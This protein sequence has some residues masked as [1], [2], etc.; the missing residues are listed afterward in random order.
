MKPDLLVAI[1]SLIV[2]TVTS[3]F[4]GYI[5]FLTLRFAARPRLRIKLLPEL[6]RGESVFECCDSATLRFHMVNVGH[7]YSKP[8]ATNIRLYINFDLPP[9]N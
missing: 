8:A 2:S 6:D 4:L 3:I 1:L 7:W 9:R 5:A